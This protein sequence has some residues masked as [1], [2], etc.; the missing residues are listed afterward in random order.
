MS[1]T[2]AMGDASV[3]YLLKV[4]GWLLAG[5]LWSVATGY[6]V[7][8]YS[9]SVPIEIRHQTVQVPYVSALLQQFGLITFLVLMALTLVCGLVRKVPLVNGAAYFLLTGLFGVIVA[10]SISLANAYAAAGAALTGHPVRDAAIL[11]VLTCVSLSAYVVVSGHDFSYLGSTLFTGLWVL[12]GAL[13]LG[14]FFGSRVW[15]L[16]ISSVAVIL[17]SLFVLYDT[18]VILDKSDRES[19]IGDALQLYLDVLNL[20]VH[21]LRIF[22]GSSKS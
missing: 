21:L 8:N 1:T 6:W 9:R 11:T 12:I 4:Y 18:S 16:A 5:V 15:D 20:F 22:G 7:L 17:F 19:P 13:V 2:R 10:P 14:L 3:S